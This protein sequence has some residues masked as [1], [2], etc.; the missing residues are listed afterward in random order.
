MTDKGK[1]PWSERVPMLAINPDA[2]TRD[3]VARLASEL[4]EVN[5]E[6]KRLKAV[7]DRIHKRAYAAHCSPAEH[8]QHAEL[9]SIACDADQALKGKDAGKAGK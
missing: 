5:A 4:M 8:H 1:L 7:L 2:A 6:N 9:Y 3:D